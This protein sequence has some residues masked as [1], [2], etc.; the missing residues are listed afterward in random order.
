MPLGDTGWVNFLAHLVLAP[1][2]PH[3]LVGSIAPDLI[4]GPLPKT[5]HPDVAAAAREHQRIDRFTDTHRAFHR[6]RQRLAEVIRPRFAG[7]LTD[8]LYDHILASNWPAWRTDRF[9]VY[10][11]GCEEV[12]AS[13]AELMPSDM[14]FVVRKMIDEHWLSSYATAD[15]LH[16]RLTQMSARLSRRFGR[17]VDLC[18]PITTIRAVARGST[19]DFNAFWPELLHDVRNERDNQAVGRLAS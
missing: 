8:V 5:L 12:L 19:D 16:A 17:V 1:Q 11:A 3:G 18:P 14:R 10:T 13:H 2:T 6:T 9:D 7:V 15:G 4:R